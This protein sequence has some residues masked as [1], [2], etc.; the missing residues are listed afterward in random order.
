MFNF[1]LNQPWV[2]Y[3]TGCP[4]KR[5]FYFG[6]IKYILKLFLLLCF[7]VVC[8]NF[9][10]FWWKLVTCWNFSKHTNYFTGNNAPV[11]I[12]NHE[13][14]SK[15][16]SK[17]KDESKK[18]SKDKH[19]AELKKYSCS[20]LCLDLFLDS[21]LS[22]CFRSRVLDTSPTHLT[23]HISCV[24]AQS[25]PGEGQTCLWPLPAHHLSSPDPGVTASNPL[26]GRSYLLGIGYLK[27]CQ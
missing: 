5:L 8:N 10:S 9:P 25:T 12:V 23:T 20:D 27:C 22:T 2:E 3:T 13:N 15:N 18:E 24:L 4:E 16:E 11:I 21:W 7:A 6:G 17:S 19:W 14:E 1:Q 26:S